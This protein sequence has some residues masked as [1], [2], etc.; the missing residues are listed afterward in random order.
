MSTELKR[1]LYNLSALADLGQEITSENAFHEKMQAVFYVITGTFLANKGAI[2]SYDRSSKKLDA[3]TQKGFTS[4]D[5][6]HLGAEELMALEKNEPCLAKDALFLAVIGAEVLV[7]LW[8]RDQFIGALLLGDKVTAGSYTPEDLELLKII[9]T[10]IAITLN[11]HSLF[12]DLSD[13]LEENHRLY[14]EMRRIYH[15]TIQAFAAAIDAKDAYTQNHSHR[16]AK[17][18]SAIA[19][20]LGW[21]DH[22]IEGIY[23]AGYLHDV[24]KLAISNELLNKVGP[25]TP[26]EVEEIRKHSTLSHNIAAKINF[27]WKNVED[28]VWHHHERLDGHG[29]PDELGRESL[30]DGVRIITLADSFDAMTSKRPYREKMDVQTALVEL[31]KCLNSQFDN[32][33]MLVLC[34]VLDKEIKGELPEPEILPNLDK[35]SDLTIISSLLEGIIAELS[36][37]QSAA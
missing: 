7:P 24:G 29:Y 3:L 12:I 28:M 34:K 5:L 4:A 32:K 17:Y 37:T 22:D 36:A 15:G 9:A 2:L 11:H 16:V 19:R 27:P 8:V 21:N 14:E 33:I 35:N 10:Q 31:K 18:S 6:V 23:V 30:S 25:F 26:E 1:A 13:K 20:E